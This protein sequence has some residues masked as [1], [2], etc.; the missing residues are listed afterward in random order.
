[1]R[2]A[3]T[4]VTTL[5]LGLG[6][7]T[8]CSTTDP[9][10]TTTPTI[11][12]TT[13]TASTSPIKSPSPSVTP[14][15]TPSATLDAD[16]LAA[17]SVVNEFFR[18]S[19]ELS[20]NPE[21]PLQPLADITT[22]QTQAIYVKEV[23]DFRAMNAI[24]IGDVSWIVVAVGPLTQGDVG[25]VVVADVCT[26]NSAMDVIDQQTKKSILPKGGSTT[27]R[28]TIDVVEENG[29]WRVGDLTTTTVKGC[30]Q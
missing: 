27:I 23:A 17:Q 8:A 12:A 19:N 2:T 30:P 6:A 16:Q 22:G 24:Q 20:R 14:S 26:D 15:T 21:L 10:P 7:L 11:V 1:M 9:D 28:W 3:I 29:F 18:I 4:A 13:P 25:K 5:A